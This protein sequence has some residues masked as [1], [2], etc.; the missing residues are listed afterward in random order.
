[1]SLIVSKVGN[2]CIIAL[3]LAGHSV[4]SL[5]VITSDTLLANRPESDTQIHKK[6]PQLMKGVFKLEANVLTARES[7]SDRCYNTLS[8]T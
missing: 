1:M 7:K 4:G 5:D 2:P 3:S 6:P 8:T